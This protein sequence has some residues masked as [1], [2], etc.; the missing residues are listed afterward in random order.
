M[1][2]FGWISPFSAEAHPNSSPSLR[3]CRHKRHPATM[4]DVRKCPRHPSSA[5]R[6]DLHHQLM[7]IDAFMST[8]FTLISSTSRHATIIH[9]QKH[10]SRSL[11]CRHINVL[12]T[13]HIYVISIDIN[14]APSA[15]PPGRELAPQRKIGPPGAGKAGFGKTD[16]K[17][18]TN[19]SPIRESPGCSRIA[20]R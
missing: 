17:E 6:Q 10:R 18:A 1:L 7:S 14:E 12:P 2:S 16:A 20:R 9:K 13:L 19:T 3:F 4:N 8:I 11:Q 15:Y 5:F